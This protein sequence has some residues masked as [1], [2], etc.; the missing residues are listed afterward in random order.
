[1]TARER[2][3]QEGFTLVEA[4]VAIVVLA[5]GLIAVTNLFLV[6]G[7]SNQSANHSTAAATQATEVLEALKAIPFNALAC[8]GALVGGGGPPPPAPCQP[9]CVGTPDDC[10][11]VCVVP[12]SFN[13]Y[14]EVPGVGLVLTT[15]TIADSGGAGP[16]VRYIVVQAETTAPLVGM[17]RSQALFTTFRTCTTTGCVDPNPLCP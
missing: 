15:W 16:P 11:S 13:Y 14:R 7:T 17:R 4:L 6:G 12:G 10:P 9:D 1:M 2:K 8:G 5:F 3:D